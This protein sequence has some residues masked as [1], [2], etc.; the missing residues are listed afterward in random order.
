M[1]FDGPTYALWGDR[2]RLVPSTHAR[3]LRTALPQARIEISAGMGHHPTRERFDEVVAL[4][5]RARAVPAP[6]EARVRLRSAA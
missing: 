2:D 1:D 3:G 5:G 4:V 6:V